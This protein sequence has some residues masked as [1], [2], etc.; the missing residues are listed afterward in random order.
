MNMHELGEKI[1]N[2]QLI[3]DSQSIERVS[4][5]RYLVLRIKKIMYGDKKLGSI[6]ASDT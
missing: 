6:S 5:F 1:D 4:Y 3:R 2:A